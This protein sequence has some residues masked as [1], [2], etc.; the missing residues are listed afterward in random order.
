MIHESPPTSKPELLLNTKS[1]PSSLK[2]FEIEEITVKSP[3]DKPLV[4][5]YNTTDQSKEIEP[6][7]PEKVKV[8]PL[9][10]SGIF[11]IKGKG[12]IVRAD[13]SLCCKLTN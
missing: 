8:K 9:E 1:K 10:K 3:I 7:S 12:K 13:S 2:R 6:K 5:F 11:H 4:T